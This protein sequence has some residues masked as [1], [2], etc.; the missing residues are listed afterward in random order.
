MKIYLIIKTKKYLTRKKKKSLLQ[1]RPNDVLSFFFN[2]KYTN[3]NDRIMTEKKTK[4][5][6][7]WQLSIYQKINI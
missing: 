5:K 6:D 4:N 7:K 3:T 2:F 1:L